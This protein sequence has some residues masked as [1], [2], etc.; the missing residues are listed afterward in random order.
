MTLEANSIQTIELVSTLNASEI[1][2]VDNSDCIFQPTNLYTADHSKYGLVM[3]RTLS[4]ARKISDNEVSLSA[5]IINTNNEDI[6]LEENMIV[7]ELENISNN[8]VNLPM[9]EDDFK[10]MMNHIT[11]QE[12]GDMDIFTT[13]EAGIFTF[14]VQ[15]QLNNVELNSIF[16]R[17]DNI[18]KETRLTDGSTRTQ[19]TSEIEDIL[20]CETNIDPTDL[21]DKEELLSTRMAD[22]TC[23][24]EELKGEL[25]DI[26]DREMKS[27]WANHKWDIGETHKIK[28]DIQ[29]EEG[30][31][32][33]DKKGQSHTPD[34]NMPKRQSKH[35]WNT[36]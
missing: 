21:L 18:E 23:V 35:S 1:H 25:M 28:H 4:K 2:E 7:G 3:Q 11:V 10:A 9:G 16:N 20:Q 29:T 17:R 13:D 24:P 19:L 33:N 36:S 26:V 30:K 8:S 27:V 12:T 32:V 5:I 6:H 34:Y 22:F 14:Q 31:F 15:Q